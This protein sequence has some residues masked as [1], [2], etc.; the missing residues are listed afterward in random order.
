MAQM[1]RKRNDNLAVEALLEF[2]DLFEEQLQIAEF[3]DSR[4]DD[5]IVNSIMFR[6]QSKQ[7]IEHLK[8]LLKAFQK[9]RAM[10]IKRL[11]RSNK[12]KLTTN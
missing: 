11:H 6:T 3:F 7:H 4:L 5:S 2:D 1:M 12:Q 8:E 10:Q 9:Q